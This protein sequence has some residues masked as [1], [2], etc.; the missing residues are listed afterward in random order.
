MDPCQTEDVLNLRSKCPQILRSIQRVTP[1][2]GTNPVRQWNVLL[3][4]ASPIDRRFPLWHQQI[5]ADLA[6]V[7]AKQKKA[8]KAEAMSWKKRKQEIKD[9]QVKDKFL[10]TLV[11][12]DV[13]EKR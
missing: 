10:G 12:T 1:T 4:K 9:L 8:K 13:T 3:S 5:Y 11:E 6:S 2:Y 7:R